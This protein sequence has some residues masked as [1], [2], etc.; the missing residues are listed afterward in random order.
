MTRQW[1]DRI[2]R[3][4]RRM[5]EIDAAAERHRDRSVDRDARRLEQDAGEL[6]AVEQHIIRPFDAIGGLSRR[7]QLTRDIV[8]GQCRDEADLRGDSGR[9]ASVKQKVA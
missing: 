3:S 8:D 9:A 2:G 7:Q 5:G 1:R 4:L 6:R